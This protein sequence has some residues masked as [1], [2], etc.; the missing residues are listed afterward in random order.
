MFNKILEEAKKNEREVA[1]FLRDLIATRS[2]SSQ[3]GA[4]IQRVKQ[5]MEKCNFDEVTIDPMGNISG[6]SAMENM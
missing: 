1:G 4:C 2:M 5:E 3:E 6:E